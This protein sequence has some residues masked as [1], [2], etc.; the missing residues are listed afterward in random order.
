MKRRS[1]TVV[2]L[3]LLAAVS[4]VAFAQ[5]QEIILGAADLAPAAQ[6]AEQPTQGKW[7][8]K[9]DAHAWGA[10]DG[11][12]LMTGWPAAAGEPVKGALFDVWP[13]DRFVPYRVSDL[14]IE[15]QAS[16]W[17]RIYLGLYHEPQEPHALLLGSLS[18]E[19]YPEYLQASQ[20]AEGRVVE[21]YWKAADLTGRTIRL[22]QP[23]AP[24]FHPGSGWLAGISYLRLVRVPEAGVPA[25]RKEGE[26]PP[27]ERRLFGMLDY[28][29][30]VFWWGSIQ[31]Q[32]DL[33]AVIYRHQQAGFGRI[34]FRSFGTA[35][36]HALDLPE[37]AP[38]W[39]EAD[40]ARWNA[41]QQTK[42]GWA[43]YIDLSRRFDPL[44]TAVEYGRQIGC[45]VHAWVRLTNFNRE[46]YANF[47]HD[48]PELQAQTLVTEKDPQT[49]Q[50]VPVKPYKLRPYSRVLSFAYP[51]V[52]TFYVSV[53]KRIAAT[54]TRGIM[55]DLLRHPP[56]AGYEPIVAD[57]FQ[58]RY[59]ADLR[60][61][62]IY[63]DPQVQEHLSQYLRLFLVELREAIGTDI[64][65][66]VRCS[67]PN[68]FALRGK[69]WI[70]EGLIDTIVDGNWYSGNGPRPSIGET[71]AA[72]GT[73]GKALAVAE[74]SDVDP[75]Q[76]WKARPGN[77]SPE[78]I[79]ALARHYSG[80]GVAAFGL[81]E[82]TVFVW[83]P[84]VRRA[85]RAA[86]WEYNPSRQ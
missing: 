46:P 78:A 13:A 20:R 30:E 80:R 76:G 58:A 37:A 36:D 68:N 21:V 19:P 75:S 24:L 45:D 86:G 73:R 82:T 43:A 38:R 1:P 23:P 72:V 47:W 7:W 33:R 11:A 48:H 62:N 79:T 2:A 83:S 8:L 17:H 64:E 31:N 61:R 71:V 55:I 39:T 49:G 15:P 14:V 5:Q 35:L 28:P 85:I 18:G 57:S 54:G 12:I 10:R 69:E 81:Y 27:R 42:A 52:R 6:R 22:A 63:R 53:F 25:V 59:G 4:S 40:E 16:G 9:R 44:Q 84:D 3:A 77:L 41:R 74:V 65:L 26:L 51:Q 56:I 29:D 66:S 34:Y 70:D 32:D 60:E 67:G 50:S